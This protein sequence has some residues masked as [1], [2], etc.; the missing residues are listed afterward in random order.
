MTA[1][2]AVPI[3]KPE[4][5]F[6]VGLMQEAKKSIDEMFELGVIRHSNSEWCFQLVPVIKKDGTIRMALDFRPLNEICKF[7]AFPMPRV[8]STLEKLA[9]AKVFSKIDLTKGYYQME[10]AEEDCCKTAFRFDGQLY[11]FVR[12]PFGLASAPQSFQ[13]LM[14]KVLGD[15]PFV[16]IYLDDVIIFS[17]DTKEHCRHLAE[18][19]KRLADANLRINAKKCAFGL[20]EINFLGFKIRNNCR[21]PAEEKTQ[22]MREFPTPSSKKAV[23]EFVGLTNYFRG[24]IPDYAQIAAPLY[25]LSEQESQVRMAQQARRGV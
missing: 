6:P 15:L 10:I 14:N 16:A 22:T 13:R 1:E 12:T 3:N 2:N 24:L 19:F 11:E 18:V 17:G 21:L 7:D 5:R 20:T 25:G 9:G 23:Q 4:R 8:D